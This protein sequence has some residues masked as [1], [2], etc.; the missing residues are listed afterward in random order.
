MREYTRRSISPPVYPQPTEKCPPVDSASILRNR[1]KYP[2]QYV[3]EGN[4]HFLNVNSHGQLYAGA[5]CADA[6][7]STNG[8]PDQ[9]HVRFN[10]VPLGRQLIT[11][12]SVRRQTSATER[13]RPG[14]SGR[15]R[16][17]NAFKYS[18]D[19]FSGS[20]AYPTSEL[21][22]CRLSLTHLPR[23]IATIVDSN[24]NV[25]TLDDV[26]LM[27][28]SEICSKASFE[29]TPKVFVQIK[30][31]R[32]PKMAQRNDSSSVPILEPVDLQIPNDKDAN[33]CRCSRSV[34]SSE[35]RIN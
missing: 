13:R 20:C 10:V 9:H 18:A 11:T 3:N 32:S 4:V 1:D 22:D 34:D 5:Q 2:I 30:N 28:D 8:P 6:L 12:S 15:N 23:R 17:T 29:S 35:G 19:R 26:K 7:L 21:S 24:T 14:S 33:T 25:N 27:L 16:S 31:L